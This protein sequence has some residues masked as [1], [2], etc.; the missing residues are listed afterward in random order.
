MSGIDGRLFR[1]KELVK[2]EILERLYNEHG[3]AITIEV[4]LMLNRLGV[5]F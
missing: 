3:I 4:I 2:L 5:K 1:E